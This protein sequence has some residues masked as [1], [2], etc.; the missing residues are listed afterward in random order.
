MAAAPGLPHV[1]AA[2]DLL[3]A[4]VTQLYSMR[5]ARIATPRSADDVAKEKVF[6][7]VP[8]HKQRT[9]ARAQKAVGAG[10]QKNA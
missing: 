3:V 2:P 7:F 5:V 4:N 6:S 9:H 8:Y 10:P 1:L